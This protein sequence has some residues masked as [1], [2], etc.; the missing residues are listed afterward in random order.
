MRVLIFDTKRKRLASV[1]KHVKKLGM[2]A[3]TVSKSVG[4]KKMFIQEGCDLLILDSSAVKIIKTLRKVDMTIP[5]V[6]LADA[7]IPLDYQK[8][9][10]NGIQGLLIRPYTYQ[11]FRKVVQKAITY[12]KGVLDSLQT[13]TSLTRK[14]RE[15]RTLSEIVQAINSS[16][17]PEEILETI[18]AKAADL[19]KAEGWSVLLLDYET[20]ELVF[21][22]AAG[23]AG[24][25]LLG[26][27]LKI[28][29]GV[30]GWAARHGQSLIVPD[31]KKDP[32]FYSG[33]DEKTKF[34]TKSILCVPMRSKNKI[35]GVVEV[36]NKIGGEPFTDDDL[37]IF[38]NLVAHVTI[39]LENAAIYRKMEEASLIDD[40]TKLYNLRYC[41]QYL[42]KFLTERKS[43]FGIVSLIFLDIDFFKLVDDNFGHLV[44]S[45]TLRRVG[46]RLRRTVR[47]G[48]VLVRYGGDEYIV[49]LPNTDKQTA[50]AIAERIRKEVSR[51]PFFTFDNQKFSISVT[52][53]VATYPE[54]AKTRDELIG[55][56]DKAMYDGKLSGRDKVVVA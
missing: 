33:I 18:M 44:G 45:E 56:A 12:R 8:L 27:R 36:I 54:D 39:A 9:I 16:L 37:E 11:F 22:A 4:I 55:K 2:D 32:R 28:G 13:V 31:V 51:E 48:D 29:Q 24:K 19:I 23:E 6:I 5:I 10:Q 41:N 49:I 3:V 17:R 30:A 46:E 47:K 34:V 35:I 40:L 53:G 42:D 26:M 52:L 50:T 43:E 38:E 1:A 25:K 20:R 15:L 7:D 14:I 21:K